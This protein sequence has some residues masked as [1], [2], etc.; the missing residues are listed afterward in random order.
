MPRS[1]AIQGRPSKLDVGKRMA[2]RTSEL[3]E[4]LLALRRITR[5]QLFNSHSVGCD[6]LQIS[7]ASNFKVSRTRLEVERNGDIT[8]RYGKMQVEN[9]GTANGLESERDGSA[10]GRQ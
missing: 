9:I 7:L 8:G 4:D 1:N 6:A 3:S 2:T 5:E 10:V